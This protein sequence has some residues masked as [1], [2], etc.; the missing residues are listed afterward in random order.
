MAK[1]KLRKGTKY[2]FK[3]LEKVGQRILMDGPIKNIRA[4][5]AMY[6]KNNP[7]FE[8]VITQYED[9]SITVTRTA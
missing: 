6:K 4:S 9:G 2:P 7:L 1:L 5:L 3:H 8:V